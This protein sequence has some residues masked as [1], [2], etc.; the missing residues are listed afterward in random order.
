MIAKPVG[1]DSGSPARA[2]ALEL[3]NNLLMRPSHLGLSSEDIDPHRG[4][5]WVTLR[6]PARRS[7]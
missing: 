6:K 7:G 3:F 2:D 5:L 1:V 4:E